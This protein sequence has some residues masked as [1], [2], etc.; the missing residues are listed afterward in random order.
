LIPPGGLTIALL[1]YAS[2]ATA[3]PSHGIARHGMPALPAGFPHLPYANPDAPKGG[4]LVVGSLG[5]FDSMNPYISRG[6]VPEVSPGSGINTLI[7]QP[8]MMRS[9]DEPFTL[10]GLVA[11]SIETAADRSWVEFKLN[12]LARFSDGKPVTAEDVKFTFE[13]LRDRGRPVQRS[14]SRR[15][16]EVSLP[17]ARTIRFTFAEPDG[18]LPLILALMPTLARRPRPSAMASTPPPVARWSGPARWLSP[19][20]ACA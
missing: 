11:E 1:V 20:A 19:S 16:K 9:L 18:E 7:V 17:D 15:V 6:A 2:V 12:P 4:R 14:S 5:T 3:Q 8:L 13:L 10:Y